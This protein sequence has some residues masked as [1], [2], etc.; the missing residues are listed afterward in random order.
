MRLFLS[1]AF[2][3]L[4]IHFAQAQV[5]TVLDKENQQPIFN[6]SIFNKD[7]ST[8]VLTDFDGRADL[9]K[10]S[11]L[12]M[13]FFRH[14]SHYEIQSTK[15]RILQDDGIIFLT[16]NENL[17]E[18]VVLSVSKF[19]QQRKEVPQKIISIK[20]SDIITS[21]PQT[22]ADLLES[23]G[24]VY[25]Q[26]SQ[27]GGGSPM[28]RGFATNRLLIT[29]DGVR[30]NT[31]IFRG[32]NLQNVI[33]IN[34]LTIEKTEIVLGPGS[35]IYGS[36]AI[37]GV[38]NFY[39]LTP[40][41]S[42]MQ[43]G[44]LSGRAYTRYATAN[45]EKTTHV[46]LSYGREQWAFLSSATY[47]DFGDLR[48]GSRGPEEF[49]RPEYIVRRDGQ[50]VILAN[51]DPRVQKPTGY[52]QINFLQKV[53][54]RPTEEWDFRLGAIYSTTSDFPRYDRLYRKRGEDLRS[55]EWYYGPQ[56]WLQTNFQIH[57]LG[58]GIVYDEAKLTTAYQFFEES[59]HDRDYLSDILF[60]TEE[61][62][63]A[64][65]GN[66][67]F[68][69][70]FDRNNLFYGFEYVLNKV[71]SEGG[72]R[73]IVSGQVIPG[74]SRYPDNSSWQSIAA[75]TSF[76]WKLRPDL[77][78]QTGARYNH[79]LLNAA[80]DE[81]IYDFPFSEANLNSGAVTGSV[82]LNWQQN[83]IFGWQVNLASAF[84]APNID[85]IGKIFDSAPGM[86]VVPNPD[87]K[88]ET[89]Y[90]AEL[91][92]R[93][94][95]NDAVHFEIV[96]FY[97]YL[98]DALV[99]RDYNLNGETIIDYQGEP[100]RVQAIQ[101]A[102]YANVY[103]LEIA[104]VVKFSDA[105]KF[106]SHA[107]WTKGEEEQEDGTKAPLRHAAP[108]FGTARIIWEKNAF[109]FDIF[110]E[111]NGEISY[112]ELAPSEIDKAYLYAI[113]PQGN[114]YSPEWYT[115]N[116]TGQ[117]KISNHWLATASLENI[118]DQ[119]YRTYSSGLAAA[120]RNFILALQYVF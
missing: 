99:R 34:P 93:L 11:P 21:G 83:D 116:I 50:D 45:E 42:R 27:L 17:L 78:M 22:A 89:S 24:Q 37:G 107:N 80:F 106:T 73:N 15:K 113:D 92:S 100:S 111:Y 103:G 108:F 5:I 70:K 29:V 47:S 49:L 18:E 25:V 120:G 67:D 117:Y 28:I 10:F 115:L 13:L 102:A 88:P 64:W 3:F 101:N 97:T 69:K 110:G 12:E 96:G 68:E 104:T 61:Q 52:N 112:S 53:R 14:V 33:S 82:G 31:A 16:P 8:I 6:V 55:A 39:T 109:R 85:D 90:N 44:T 114:P 87:L 1:L 41:F 43:D 59:R 56:E 2:L 30:M 66:L 86:V 98:D 40:E 9:S 63:D 51:E 76:Q 60:E 58:K 36:D 65:S 7:K 94:N 81:E 26:K 71:D 4:S 54:F 105:L 62:V 79:F 48:M 23:T 84:R 118:T 32:G 38:M 57:K 95:F 75:Y 46:D 19:D 74:M 35:V 119:R 91:G 77:N 20:R 72:E